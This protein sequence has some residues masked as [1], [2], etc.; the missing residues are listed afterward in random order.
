MEPSR[1]QAIMRLLKVWAER[2]G[3]NGLAQRV[4]VWDV[5]KDDVVDAV[6]RNDLL[7]DLDPADDPERLKRRALDRA[8]E[9]GRVRRC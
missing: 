7:R 3:E 5:L 1:H 2:A 4:T 8:R 6:V 9:R